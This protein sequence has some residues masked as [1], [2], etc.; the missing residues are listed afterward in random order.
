[1]DRSKGYNLIMVLKKYK[2]NL[3]FAILLV[4]NFIPTAHVL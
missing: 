2:V 3:H 1:M 4:A